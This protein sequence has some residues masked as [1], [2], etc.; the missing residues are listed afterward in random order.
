MAFKVASLPLKRIISNVEVERKFNP[1]PMLLSFLSRRPQAQSR[2][3]F[4]RQKGGAFA[5]VNQPGQL[6]RDTYYD[7]DGLLGKLGLWVRQRYV[8]VLPPDPLRVKNKEDVEVAGGPGLALL[9]D[10]KAKAKWNAKLR[11]GGRF[12]NSEF[13]EFNGKEDVSSEILRITGT[14]TGLEDLQ[15]V[16][17]L[18]TCRSVWEVT[19]LPDGTA[20]S[21][22]MTIVIDAV[23]EAETGEDARSDDES[24]PAFA[25]TIGEVELFQTVVTEKEDEVEHEARRK[26]ISTQMMGQLEAFML[27][28]TDL[29][30][31]SPPPLGKLTAYD[32]WKA[33]KTAKAAGSQ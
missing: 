4:N 18:Q 15:V 8:H 33:A 25:H 16:E 3:S 27:A 14:R 2:E 11:I 24:A 32:R 6:I 22:K 9:P 1:N 31:T 21:A 23:T 5:V 20:P 19:Q 10:D 7:T 30:P 29:F 26:E 17:D 13:V 28:H 12:T